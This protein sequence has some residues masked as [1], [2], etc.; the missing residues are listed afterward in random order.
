MGINMGT[1][2]VK[3]EESKKDIERVMALL[4]MKDVPERQAVVIVADG[5]EINVK[6]ACSYYDIEKLVRKVL[7][8]SAKHTAPRILNDAINAC[9]K[10]HRVIVYF[11]MNSNGTTK[12][13]IC[14]AKWFEMA[15]G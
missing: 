14:A 11:R 10:D 5:A 15:N 13:V 1:L 7:N 8:G 2:E 3:D 6:A 9:E 12:Y 4:P